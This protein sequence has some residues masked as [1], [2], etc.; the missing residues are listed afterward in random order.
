MQGIKRRITYVFFYELITLT[1]ISTAFFFFSDS[2]ATHAASLGVITVV[3]AIVWNFIFNWIFEQWESTLKT[4]GRNL[5]RRILHALGFE[6]GFIAITL[7][8]FAW[9]LGITMIEA[10]WLDVGLTLFFMF[11]TFVYAWAFDRI[12]GLPLSAQ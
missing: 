6:I 10:F 4:R 12:F 3:L 2:D 8:L 5:G 9:W 1:I 11:F 7:P